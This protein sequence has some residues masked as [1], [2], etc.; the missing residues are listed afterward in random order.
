LFFKNLNNEELLEEVHIM[1]DTDNESSMTFEISPTQQK[2]ISTQ[3]TI[4][5]NI[6]S[7]KSKP[8]DTLREALDTLKDIRQHVQDNEF[9]LFGQ[10][11]GI[12][13]NNLPL[14]KAL[15]MQQKI[16]NLMYEARL[17]NLITSPS[18][19]CSTP[20]PSID[21][22]TCSRCDNFVSNPHDL[23]DQNKIDDC[24]ANVKESHNTGK[25]PTIYFSSWNDQL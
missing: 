2:M 16:Q 11:V 15:E 9:I 25:V 13:L 8:N 18:L 5:K 20:I 12:Q 17:D 14:R 1:M 7:K 22:S 4:V 10:Q 19:N 21:R 23:H 24:D 3:N 6:K